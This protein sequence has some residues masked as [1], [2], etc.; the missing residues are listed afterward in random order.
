[1]APPPSP[2]PFKDAA[3][4]LHDRGLVVV[5]A[6]GSDGKVPLVKGFTRRVPS[7]DTLRQWELQ[8]PHANI[9]ICCHL[10]DVTI[11]DVDDPEIEEMITER[12]GNTPLRTRTPSGGV[13]LWYR[14][15]GERCANLRCHDIAADVKAVGGF[16]VVPPSTRLGNGPNA[17]EPYRFVKGTW[18]DLGQLPPV[19]AGSLPAGS[20]NRS[21]SAT[22]RATTECVRNDSLFRALLRE[23]RYCN[24][25][26]ALF[27]AAQSINDA[28]HPP[29][30]Q[31][32][33]E[34]IVGSVW[35]YKVR[36]EIW[37]G[38]ESQIITS[39]SELD[40]LIENPNAFALR[41]V[42]LLAHG[43]RE[44]A[45]A[46]SPKA[47]ARNLVIPGW[48]PGAYRKARTWLVERGFLTV[49]HE[50]GRCPGDVGL[51]TL[52]TPEFD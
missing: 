27:D 34:K 50:G 9:G 10:S 23:A 1:M 38:K 17:G 22:P 41:S 51:F 30:A 6:G 16:V 3:R 5:P 36:G 44:D 52:S 45:F 18:D 12:F 40:I 33:V 25:Q 20:G 21:Q 31:K 46:L 8:F 13:H 26:D 14:H 11:V 19:K 15:N 39:A 35:G 4:L 37:V 24:D 42:L 28:Y 29:M 48:G 43:A 49:V 32:E 7:I 47:M 2:T